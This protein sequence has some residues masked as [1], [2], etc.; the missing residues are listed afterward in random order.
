MS[1]ILDA[2]DPRGK[3]VICS[4]GCWDEH[5]LSKR[6]SMS[7][8]I[9]KLPKAIEEPDAIFKDADFEDRE[10]YYLLAKRNYLKVVVRFQGDQGEV[11]TAFLTDSPKPGETLLWVK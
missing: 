6:P 10:V 4:S 7:G 5:I 8:W 1:N 9:K 11:I 2:T 3:K